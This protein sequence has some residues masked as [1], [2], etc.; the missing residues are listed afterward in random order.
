MSFAGVA[1]GGDALVG[2][3]LWRRVLMRDGGCWGMEWVGVGCWGLWAGGLVW[4]S[5]GGLSGRVGVSVGCF[6]QEASI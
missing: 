5:G 3:A 6:G 4:V 2:G 1:A